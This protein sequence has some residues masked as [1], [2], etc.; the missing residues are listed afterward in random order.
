MASK[1]K[2]L[3]SN[4]LSLGVIQIANFIMP[5]ISVPII[6]RIMG[7]EKFGAVNLVGA[8]IMYLNVFIGYGFNLTATRQI[9]T[10]PDNLQHRSKVF[11]EVF[12]SQCLLFFVSIFIYSGLLLT[13]PSLAMEKKMAFFAFIFCIS[14]VLTQNWIFQAMQDLPKVAVLNLFGKVIYLFS[15]LYFITARS[16][17]YLQPLILSLS[18]VAVA[19]SSF[20]WAKKKYNLRLLKTS[21]QTCI[22]LLWNERAVFF[23][24]AFTMFY[25]NLNIV[26]L[27]VLANETEVGYY[28]AGQRLIAVAQ[29]V[30]T[31]P[32]AQVL[33]PYVSRAFGESIEKGL[34]MT[35]K[36][37]PITLLLTGALCFVIQVFGSQTLSLFYGDEFAPA[38][39]AFKILAFVPIFVALNNIFSMQLM[40]NLKMDKLYSKITIIG[41]LFSILLNYL[42]VS[43]W[44][45]IG[46]AYNWL[47]TELFICS[48]MYIFLLKKGIQ[49]F[50]RTFFSLNHVL[51]CY[52]MLNN[53][54]TN[55]VKPTVQ[56]V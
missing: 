2:S 14:S 43:Q 53:R 48:T 20:Y 56:N 38:V 36:V 6:S 8:I 16:D 13:V 34:H 39:T 7:P 28:T 21:V 9:L 33:Y 22:S 11:S 1:S 45:Y 31:L 17:Y 25:T 10:D 30:I 44:G 24:I 32:L 23:S 27:S 55:K 47:A 51:A 12:F 40:L 15:V 4:L 5:L 35:Q 52:N 54:F 18:Q 37:V 26:V 41:A 50:N 29:L 42:M 19:I 46:C 3:K 49:P